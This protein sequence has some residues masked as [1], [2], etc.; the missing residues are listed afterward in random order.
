MGNKTSS[1]SNIKVVINNKGDIIKLNGVNISQKQFNKFR[2]F[3]EFKK[4]IEEKG[5]KLELEDIKFYRNGVRV[6][7]GLTILNGILGFYWFVRLLQG[8][9]SVLMIF[10]LGL[11]G[12]TFKRYREYK[13][14]WND[15]IAERL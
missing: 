10:E 2:E 13:K 7:L 8:E 4:Y 1:G 6:M 3:D 5:E 15:K 11:I 14:K 12:Y 9:S